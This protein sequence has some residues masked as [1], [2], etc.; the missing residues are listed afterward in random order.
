LFK[1]IAERVAA[2]TEH[3]PNFLIGLCVLGAIV[4]TTS[5]LFY[6]GLGAAGFLAGLLTGMVLM[7]L[8]LISAKQSTATMTIGFLIV[9]TALAV[10]W[11]AS[12]GYLLHDQ[13]KHL[14][15]T[16]AELLTVKI[17]RSGDRGLLYFEPKSNQ[18]GFAKWDA[19]KRISEIW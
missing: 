7:W 2:S 6:F 8:K 9:V 11:D 5:L 18:L 10:G 14:V 19:I 4:V 12:R 1:P 17:I 3:V 16:E 13:A 15:Q